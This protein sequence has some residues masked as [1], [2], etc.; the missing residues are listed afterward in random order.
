MIK[1]KG[2]ANTTDGCKRNA[3]LLIYKVI[4]NRF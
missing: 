1:S 4:M 3:Y 2:P